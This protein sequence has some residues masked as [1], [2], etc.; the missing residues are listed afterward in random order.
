MDY[1]HKEVLKRLIGT[2]VNWSEEA[3]NNCSDMFSSILVWN[4]N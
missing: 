1:L 2:V 3:L 4:N